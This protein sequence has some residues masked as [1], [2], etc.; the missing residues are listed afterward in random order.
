MALRKER[1]TPQLLLL[2]REVF[3]LFNEQSGF[4]RLL[5]G[6]IVLVFIGRGIFLDHDCGS[7]PVMLLHLLQFDYL[8]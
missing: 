6:M 4:W 2:I 8:I 3:H 1:V 7:V 5:V